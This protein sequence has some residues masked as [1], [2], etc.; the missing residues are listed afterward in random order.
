MTVGIYRVV[1]RQLAPR[2][3][4]D[5]L[6]RQQAADFAVVGHALATAGAGLQL[7]AVPQARVHVDVDAV[8]DLRD[9]TVVGRI[10]PQLV[11]G[12]GELVRLDVVETGH[13]VA[14]AARETRIGRRDDA[15]LIEVRGRDRQVVGDGEVLQPAPRVPD[16]DRHAG[17][18]LLLQRDAHLPVGRPRPPA[19]EN[20][21]GIA[22]AVDRVAG[23]I[24]RLAEIR[25]G[26]CGTEVAARAAEVLRGAVQEVAVGRV[27]TVG[28]GPGARLRELDA[29][30]RKQRRVVAVAVDRGLE[31]LAEVGFDGRLA[32]AEHVVGD[33]GARGDVVVA[34]HAFR[35]R[36]RELRRQEAHARAADRLLGVVAPGVVVAHCAAERE[37]AAGELIL[38]EQRVVADARVGLVGL[39][40]LRHLVGDAVVEAVGEVVGAAFL[41]AVV[42]VV[43]ALVAD[44]DAVGAAHER[45]RR[46]PGVGADPVGVPE[47]LVAIVEAGDA[48]VLRARAAPAEGVERLRR[49]AL[50]VHLDHRPPHVLRQRLV[51]RVAFARVPVRQV[52][53]E[54][55]FEEQA[56]GGGGRPLHLLDALP[57]VVAAAGL[58]RVGGVAGAEAVVAG[59]LVP[60]Q[61]Q[62]VAR[63]QL[64]REAQRRLDRA[65]AAGERRTLLVG[66]VAPLRRIPLVLVVEHAGDRVL[67]AAVVA[68]EVE[69]DLV[70]LDRA[71]E[72]VA[73]VVD[74]VGLGRGAQA[75]GLQ[76]VGVVAGLHPTAEAGEEGVRAEGVA[77]GARDEVDRG[78]AHFGFAQSAG[79]RDR[80]FRGVLDVL[81]VSGYAAAVERCAGVEPVH[82]R[83]PLVAAAAA[84][85]E[86]HHAGAQLHVGHAAAALHHRRNQH[87]QPGVALGSGQR[88]H[89]I[90]VERALALGALHVHDRT[91]AR[92]RNRLL[93]PADAHVGVHGG[94]ELRRQHE[95]LALEGAEPGQRERNRVGAGAQIDD[96]VQPVGVAYRRPDFFNQHIAGCLDGHPRE[97][98]ARRV[99]DHAVD[100]RLGLCESRR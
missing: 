81:A 15:E 48:A 45:R 22:R 59:L 46:V 69:P 75:R 19:F 40:P 39:E 98:G 1:V 86:H 25:V 14:A 55:R 100:R 77:A 41:R 38:Q 10:G 26:P 34:D 61:V 58:R 6:L 23:R 93:E 91:L 85:A 62:F 74:V 88:L 29:R 52:G 13:G 18:D 71:A 99:F 80:H 63:R 33:A 2:R 21:L 72:R 31:I 27:V 95:R 83:A 43:G 65:T 44:L 89:E 7:Q 16:L 51:F 76:F 64:Q 49:G 70:A 9:L 79:G 32:V 96:A 57:A 8:V 47:R 36:P 92:H 17:Q 12:H 30:A 94:I 82:L 3:E 84:A 66:E 87:H 68:E 28:V 90:A 53:A 35:F 60:E 24:D 67:A 97:Y 56:V 54:A 50:L 5:V 20:L 37:L 4:P 11:R 73:G 42:G 78:P